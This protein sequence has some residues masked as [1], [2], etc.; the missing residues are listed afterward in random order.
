LAWATKKLGPC[1]RFKLFICWDDKSP[2]TSSCLLG[3]W[4]MQVDWTFGLT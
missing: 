3:N 1:W 2:L 4:S